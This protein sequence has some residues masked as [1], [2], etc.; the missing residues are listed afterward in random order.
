MAR[1][2][3]P[4]LALPLVV[5]LG[6]NDG[7]AWAAPVEAPEPPEL[8]ASPPPQADLPP[9]LDYDHAV[10]GRVFVFPSIVENAEPPPI[11]A[12]QPTESDQVLPINLA[13]ALRLSNVRPLVIAFAQ[14]SVEA[15]AARLQNAQVLWLPNLNVGTDYFRHDGTDQTTDGTMILDDKSAFA[16]GAGATLNF[17]ITD[18]VF[19]PLADRQELAAREADLQTSRNDALLTVAWAYCDVQQARGMLA[20]TLDASARA[21]ALARKTEG[22]AKD[23][24]PRIEADRAKALLF[25]LRQQVA[26]QRANW[27]STSARLTRVLRLNPGAVV[28]PMEPPHL[29]ITLIAPRTDVNCLIQIGLA[30]RPELI[31]QRAMM[32]ASMERVRQEQARPLL[33]TVVVQGTGPNGY[34]NGGVFGGGPD[35]GRHLDGGRFDM[36]VGAVWTLNNL[37]AGNRSL[38]RQRVAQENEAAIAFA[39]IQDQVAQDVVQAQAQLEATATQVDD[40]MT[41]VEEALITYDGTLRGLGETR[42]S[43]DLLILVNRPQEAVAALQQLGRAYDI[44]YS[45]IGNYNRAQFQLYRALGFPSR[46][47]TCDPSIGDV[48]RV[49]TSRPPCM[50]A[51]RPHVQPSVE[52]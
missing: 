23:L 43:G 21:E 38:V 49:D 33:P 36:G 1:A 12:A 51:R 11:Q 9:R 48:Q 17:G 2:M 22:L 35:D 46:K 13:T 52:R 40:A 44:Y 26:M 32:Q 29:Q 45:A 3:L 30:N 4:V 31:S 47:L 37:G 27:R 19:R 24:V 20:G 41:A 15:A 28:V 25:D 8:I 7:R 42:G 34:F 18:A 50:A 10:N 14:A 6:L 5:W 39:N 16:A